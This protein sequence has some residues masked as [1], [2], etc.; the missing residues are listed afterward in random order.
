MLPDVACQHLVQQ[1]PEAV[2]VHS[3]TDLLAGKLLRCHV[4]QRAHH[5]PRLGRSLERLAQQPCDAE[6]DQPG[7]AIGPD[8][9]VSRL[10]V[11]M[12]DA[13]GVGV[14]QRL[15]DLGADLGG[16]AGIKGPIALQE[17]RE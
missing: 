5:H 17:G 3:W 11:A 8:E 10:Y 16:G 15:R 12:D 9:D 14:V 4:P 1:R 6:V 2:E 7:V 13:A